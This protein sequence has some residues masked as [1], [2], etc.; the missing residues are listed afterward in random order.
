MLSRVLRAYTVTL[1]YRCVLKTE[2]IQR[3]AFVC[4]L[5]TEK[6]LK[7]VN[8]DKIHANMLLE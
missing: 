1:A 4:N 8:N 7:K 2:Y 6:S 5:L 3:V